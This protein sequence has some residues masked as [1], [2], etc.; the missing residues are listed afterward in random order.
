MKNFKKE[1]KAKLNEEAHLAGANSEEFDRWYAANEDKLGEF[2]PVSAR[3]ADARGGVRVKRF[4][5]AAAFIG[6]AFVMA[7]VLVILFVTN[8][9]GE[10]DFTFN[11]DM[12]YNRELTDEE[13]AAVEGQ[14]DFID[15]MDVT[16]S[17]KLLYN[18]DNS[19]VFIIIH[20]EI[21]TQSDYYFMT[22]QIEYNEHYNFVDKRYYDDLDNSTT[23]DNFDVSYEQWGIDDSGLYTYLLRLESENLN[24]VYMEVH[25][26]EDD[27]SYILNEVL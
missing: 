5:P 17:I 20:G 10:S 13:F 15:N 3:D 25:C 4:L 2:S 16:D 7:M 27:I 11:S 1:M 6:L 23:T 24:T 19:L 21:I 22:V 9:G 18:E 14:Y 26:F 12:V 8:N